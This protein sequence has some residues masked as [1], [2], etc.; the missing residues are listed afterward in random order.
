MARSTSDIDRSSAISR[1]SGQKVQPKSARVSH[2]RHTAPDIGGT[3]YD[4]VSDDDDD[5]MSDVSSVRDITRKFDDQ[6]SMKREIEID[7]MVHRLI[8][9]TIASRAR[10]ALSPTQR[11]R[12]LE[13]ARHKKDPDAKRRSTVVNGDQNQDQI[14]RFLGVKAVSQSEMLNIVSRLYKHRPASGSRASDSTSRMIKERVGIFA[15]YYCLGDR[16]LDRLNDVPPAVTERVISYCRSKIQELYDG[17]RRDLVD[18][19]MIN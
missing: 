5:V 13:I 12:I 16:I 18:E 1:T 19:T 8:R 17:Q 7:E 15:S 11:K 4:Y 9:P 2:R 6:R 10:S 14:R 3:N